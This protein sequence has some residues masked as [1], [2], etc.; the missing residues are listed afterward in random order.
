[1]LFNAPLQF[2]RRTEPAEVHQAA[3]NM[4]GNVPIL[5]PPTRATEVLGPSSESNLAAGSNAGALKRLIAPFRNILGT[6][7]KKEG[8]ENLA[9]AGGA[10]AAGR[11]KR[12][13]GQKK[14]EKTVPIWRLFQYA[15]GFD[16]LLMVVGSV[17]AIASGIA[18]PLMTLLLGQLINAFGA[19]LSDPNYLYRQVVKIALD[20]LYLALGAGVAGYLGKALCLLNEVICR[21]TDFYPSF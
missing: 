7:R 12:V 16:V 3:L 20:F 10:P 17:A 5:E 2:R 15:D 9:P 19:N 18:R 6:G 1:M 4:A 13:K 8:P 11:G 14:L 21:S